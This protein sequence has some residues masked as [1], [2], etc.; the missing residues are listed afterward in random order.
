MEKIT[1]EEKFY[2]AP[3]GFNG[4]SILSFIPDWY[5]RWTLKEL[6]A[7]FENFQFMGPGW[8]LTQGKIP[9]TGRIYKDSLLII[10]EARRT[11]EQTEQVF[12]VCCWNH[13][14]V[15]HVLNWVI[16]APTHVDERSL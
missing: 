3:I 11:S 4:F 8:Y 1:S 7:E 9:E 15:S 10:P 13:H 2:P 5:E 14:D 16:N 12:L 6:K